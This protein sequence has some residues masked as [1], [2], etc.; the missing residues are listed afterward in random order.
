MNMGLFSTAQAKPVSSTNEVLAIEVAPDGNV[1]ISCDTSAGGVRLRIILDGT[2]L[3]NIS[4]KPYQFEA[5]SFNLRAPVIEGTATVG[6]T[7]RVT[8]GL[9]LVDPD[10]A[11]APTYQWLANGAAL[12]GQTAA[13]IVVTAQMQGKTLACRETVVGASAATGAVS[14][15]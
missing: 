11:V 8:P 6:T 13:Q 9:W 7:L 14:V 5:Q 1:T 10:T 3:P 2:A 4:L 15:G 12:Q